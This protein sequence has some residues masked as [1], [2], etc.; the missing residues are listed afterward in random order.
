[1]K[2][3]VIIGCGVIGAMVAHE[4]SQ[5]PNVQVTVLDRQPPAQ[6]ATGAAL[7]VLMGVISQKTKG[8]AWAMRQASIQRYHTL[9]PELAA[10]TR[11]P[12]RW[13]QQGILKLCF[14]GDDLSRWQALIDLR[15][16]QGWQL[17]YWQLEQI[18]ERCPQVQHP[19]VTAAIYSPQDLQID[20]TALT[21]SLVEAA[22]QRGVTFQFGVDVLKLGYDSSAKHCDWLHTTAGAVPS[23]AVVIAAG[24]GSTPLVAPLTEPTRPPVDVRPVLG[25][26]IQIQPHQPLG[27]SNFQPVITGQD[28]HLV[29]L[30][31]PELHLAY[32]VG[33]T[34]EFGDAAAIA[35]DAA[36]LET[37][38][39]GALALWPALKNATLL[40]TWSGLR[41]RPQNRPAPIVEP[42]TEGSNVIV[43]T[44]HYRNGVLLAPATAQMV[45]SL[46][47]QRILPHETKDEA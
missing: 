30:A 33:A 28:I 20:P 34:V 31:D 40:K 7:G 35:P 16:Q 37:V 43:A 3:I 24:L 32:W 8:R 13:N 26:A 1:M 14:T 12:L 15:Q 27:Q 10:L 21:L 6:A 9:L 5:I 45:K 36:Q 47:M 38:W 46:L 19:E 11:N 22:R 23:D 39:Q 25:Q 44:G 2:Q 17:E 29:P 18:R 42:L 41:P 4:I